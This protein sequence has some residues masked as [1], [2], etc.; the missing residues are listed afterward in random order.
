[1][2]CRNCKNLRWAEE[3]PGKPFFGWCDAISDSPDMDIERECRCFKPATNADIIRRM[4]DEELA[5]FLERVHND[6]CSSCCDNLY[7]CSRNNAPEPFCRRHFQEWLRV[8][9]DATPTLES[10]KGWSPELEQKLKI[11]RKRR[12]E[13]RSRR[14]DV[15]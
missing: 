5:E 3:Y 2:K 15:C 14:R 12:P 4:N 8:I 10:P 9:Q 13:R 7:W 11:R 6:P 1:M